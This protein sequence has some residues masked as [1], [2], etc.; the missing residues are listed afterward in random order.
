MLL[1]EMHN[2]LQVKLSL[3]RHAHKFDVWVSDLMCVYSF[4]YLFMSIFFFYFIL[5]SLP[6]FLSYSAGLLCTHG[7]ENCTSPSKLLSF[8][9]VA[10]HWTRTHMGA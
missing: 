7:A 4:E 3:R 10:R 5:P 8:P 2:A 1:G 9:S 6:F